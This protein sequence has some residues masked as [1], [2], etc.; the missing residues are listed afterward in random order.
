MSV[1]NAKEK[2]SLCFWVTK[3][4]TDTAGADFPNGWCNQPP[5]SV[6]GLKMIE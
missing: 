1:K 2:L 5:P 4:K 3:T 6:I